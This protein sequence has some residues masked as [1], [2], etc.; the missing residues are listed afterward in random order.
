MTTATATVKVGSIFYTSWGYDQTNVDYYEVVALSASGKTATLK[1]LASGLAEDG[2]GVVA[3]PGEFYNPKSGWCAKCHQRINRTPRGGALTH[4]QT[5]EVQCLDG[6]G[7]LI[8][9]TAATEIPAPVYKKRIKTYDGNPVLS[10]ASYANAYLW[11][12]KPKYDTIALGYTG[13]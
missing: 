12:G 10:W 8:P 5:D 1:Q 6:E 3:K 2:S 4:W 11:D 9:G 13:H 7:R